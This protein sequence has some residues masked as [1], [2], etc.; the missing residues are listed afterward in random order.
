MSFDVKL[1]VMLGD[2][3]ITGDVESYEMTTFPVRNDNGVGYH[4]ETTINIQPPQSK[5]DP[6][7]VF[8]SYGGVEYPVYDEEAKQ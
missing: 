1:R 3:D 8:A 6:I 2:L 4:Y 5:D 7:T